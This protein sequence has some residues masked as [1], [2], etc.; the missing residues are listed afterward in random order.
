MR[1]QGPWFSADCR[2]STITIVG[3]VKNPGCQT[4]PRAA[5]YLETAIVAA[6]GFTEKAGTKIQI[7]RINR[8]PR[9]LEVDLG[10]ENQRSCAREY[11]DDGTVVTV[12]KRDLPP[13]HVSGLVVNA[14]A[15][16][17]PVNRPLR[18]LD[19]IAL[20]GGVP[21][22]TKRT[23]RTTSQNNDREQPHATTDS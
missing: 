11:L 18:L 7:T 15:V 23:A 8:G 4:L 12:E 5:S 9:I 21:P 19:A 14:K 17:F 1:V 3:A 2:P 13:I 10:D 20:A 6:G 22:P 16:D